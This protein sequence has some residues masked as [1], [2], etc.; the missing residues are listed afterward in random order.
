MFKA[1][2]ENI[3]TYIVENVIRMMYKSIHQ[4]RRKVFNQRSERWMFCQQ[5]FSVF[6]VYLNEKGPSVKIQ[7]VNI[8]KDHDRFLLNKK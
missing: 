5:N 6:Y 7:L 8:V 4:W 2:S 3:F 1:T